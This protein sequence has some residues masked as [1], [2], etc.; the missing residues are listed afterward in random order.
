MISYRNL[1]E[2]FTS[3]NLSE[4]DSLT[5]KKKKQATI[6]KDIRENNTG[7]LFSVFHPLIAQR[8][9]ITDRAMLYF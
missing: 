9:Y 1:S 7:D 8:I 2:F 4:A 6:I 5:K 3:I